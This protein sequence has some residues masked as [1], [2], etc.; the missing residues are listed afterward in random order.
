M[1]TRP[2]ISQSTLG[3]R[4]AIT[5]PAQNTATPN[6]MIRLPPS[7]SPMEPATSMNEAKVSA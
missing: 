4:A 3:A 5:E 6:S 1:T 7:R 2:P